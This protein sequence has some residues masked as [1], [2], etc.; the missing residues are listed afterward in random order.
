M[1]IVHISDT[2]IQDDPIMGSVPVDNFRAC[3]AHVLAN[4]ADADMVVISG[5]LAHHGSKENY[6]LLKTL[7]AQTG[8]ASTS[9]RLMIGNHDDRSTFRAAFPETPVDKNGF[10]QWAEETPHGHFLFLDTNEP[11]THEGYYCA[12]RQAWLRATL[13]EVVRKSSSAYIFLHHNPMT[14]H[15]ANADQLGIVQEVEF[16]QILED[17]ESVIRHI[18]FGH[19]HFSLSGS[20]C[21]IP[22]SAPRST[23]HPNWPDFSGNK[24]RV[25]YGGMAANY[26]VAFLDERTTV[27]HSIDF[28]DERNAIWV[29]TEAD[30]WLAEDNI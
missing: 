23:S 20:V 30:G 29:G 6:A 10:I 24:D 19:C 21:G 2:H 13:D 8:L 5:D 3:A 4:S 18:F 28:L 22:V 15:V 16:Q 25:G 14:V 27:I 11:G 1:K 26:N 9:P 7:L 12:K 17:Y